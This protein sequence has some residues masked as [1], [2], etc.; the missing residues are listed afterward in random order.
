[1]SDKV[2]EIVGYRFEASATDSR[3]EVSFTTKPEHR[4]IRGIF[5]SVEG[6]A[7][8]SKC[9]VEIRINNRN[10][11]SYNEMQAS[12]IQKTKY[13]SIGDVAWQTDIDVDNSTI[14]VIFINGTNENLNINLNL[15]AE[16]KW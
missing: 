2:V 4:R 12:L 13:L 5:L 9:Y 15:I 6:D 14:Q 7:D 3:K 8:L 10:V 1:M 16:R 11:V